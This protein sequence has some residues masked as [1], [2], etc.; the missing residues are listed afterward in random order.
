MGEDTKAQPID[1]IKKL[2]LFALLL[3]KSTDI[4]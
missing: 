4:C 2:K 3:E 1:E